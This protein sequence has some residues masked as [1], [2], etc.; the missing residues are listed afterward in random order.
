M[1]GTSVL[2]LDIDGVLNSRAFF[3]GKSSDLLW[4]GDSLD[5]LDPEAIERLNRIV[6]AT[7][8]D[9]VLSSSW[10]LNP[11]GYIKVQHQ[12]AAQGFRGRLIDQTPYSS[13]GVRGEEIA[14]WLWDHGAGRAYACLD[15][16]PEDNH[17]GRWVATTFAEGLTDAHVEQVIRVLR[18]PL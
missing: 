12:L 14:A 17:P 10:R 7:D 15:D 16:D 18:T 4:F 5:M 8:C 1:S 3:D 6:E 13:S 2:F 9:V 11:G